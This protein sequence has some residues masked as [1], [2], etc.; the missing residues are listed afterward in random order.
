MV[1]V[2]PVDYLSWSETLSDMLTGP[3]ATVTTAAEGG[4]SLWINGQA[5]DTV[6]TAFST[7]GWSIKTGVSLEPP[8]QPDEPL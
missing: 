6:T 4:N 1:Y 8:P 3:L 2:V 7:M 5:S